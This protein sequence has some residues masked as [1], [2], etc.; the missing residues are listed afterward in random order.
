MLLPKGP[1]EEVQVGVQCLVPDHLT[2]PRQAKPRDE[3]ALLLPNR[4]ACREATTNPTTAPHRPRVNLPRPAA[5]R[6]R[7]RKDRRDGPS[8]GALEVGEAGG[9]LRHRRAHTELLAIHGSKRA[10][11]GDGE[12]IH[13]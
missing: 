9:A 10:R 2:L 1:R 3:G 4:S 8:A 7:P 12:H 11:E 5:S 13:H 6:G